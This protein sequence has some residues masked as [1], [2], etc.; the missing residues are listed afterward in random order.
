MMC[1]VNYIEITITVIGKLPP[2]ITP[3]RNIPPSENYPPQKIPPTKNS[4]LG[5]FPPSE[6]SPSENSPFG[7]FHTGKFSLGKFRIFH[8]DLS[9]FERKKFSSQK[10]HNKMFIDG[11]LRP[12]PRTP[13]RG[14][15]PHVLGLGTLMATDYGQRHISQSQTR[16][17]F[18]FTTSD[19]NFC[20]QTFHLYC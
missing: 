8:V 18:Y 10:M 9:T 5:K 17:Q 2:W 11:R 12:P 19:K 3:P 15:N 4:S 6:N 1:S 13:H 16:L 14:C 20:M 7:K